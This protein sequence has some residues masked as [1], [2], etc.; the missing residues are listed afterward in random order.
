MKKQIVTST[1]H[2]AAFHVY[3]F[4]SIFIVLVFSFCRTLIKGWLLYILFY[5]FKH[6]QYHHVCNC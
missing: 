1:I 5:N 6:S 2:K 4:I 3:S